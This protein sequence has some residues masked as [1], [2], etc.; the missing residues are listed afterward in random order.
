LAWL[1]EWLKENEVKTLAD[2]KIWKDS[3]PLLHSPVTGIAILSG[4]GCT[5]CNFSHERVREVSIHMQNMHGIGDDI[6]PLPASLQRV[7]ASHL[8]VD[9]TAERSPCEGS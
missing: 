7:F 6:G 9:P 8:S 2:C 4:N 1:E 3:M 5:D